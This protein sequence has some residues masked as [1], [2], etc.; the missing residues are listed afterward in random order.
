MFNRHIFLYLA[1]CAPPCVRWYSVAQCKPEVA[2][3]PDEDEQLGDEDQHTD[4]S[5][6]GSAT[7]YGT[8]ILKIEVKC[9]LNYTLTSFMFLRHLKIFA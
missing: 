4:V 3:S 9:T 6:Y 1:I 2:L 7:R 5:Q 8:L